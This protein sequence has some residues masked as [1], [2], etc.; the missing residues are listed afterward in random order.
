MLLEHFK[1]GFL[2]KI[3]KKETH[4]PI[5]K[6]GVPTACPAA[7]RLL[8]VHVP[9][10]HL[11][12][13]LE[14]KLLPTAVHLAGQRDGDDGHAAAEVVAAGAVAQGRAAPTSGHQLL[15]LLLLL[16]STIQRVGGGGGRGGD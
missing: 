12:L 6:V 1:S 16:L 4:L 10:V 15:L 9:H 5:G 3:T 8:L 14:G 7:K 11:Q 2:S 13:L